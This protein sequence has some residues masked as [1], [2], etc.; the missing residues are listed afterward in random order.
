[1]E[2]YGQPMLVDLVGS[3]LLA[4]APYAKDASKHREL[5]KSSKAEY[6]KHSMPANARAGSMKTQVKVQQHVTEYDEGNLKP[7]INNGGPIVAKHK[8][9]SN[10]EQC[11][12]SSMVSAANEKL[13]KRHVINLST[14]N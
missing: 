11:M 2:L 13:D 1:M 6:Q 10:V 9:M 14:G 5:I 7:S 4:N 3:S 12:S 8:G